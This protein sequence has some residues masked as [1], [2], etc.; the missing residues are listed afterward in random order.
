MDPLTFQLLGHIR[1][2]EIL[3]AAKFDH[4]HQSRWSWLSPRSLWHNIIEQKITRRV[5]SHGGD[6]A[7]RPARE[8][9]E[10]YPTRPA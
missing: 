5:L 9:P 6:A 4:L 7:A 1:Q 3:E 2:Q 8:T 10:A